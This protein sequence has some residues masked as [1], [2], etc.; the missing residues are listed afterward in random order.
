MCAPKAVISGRRVGWFGK[1]TA[2]GPKA[3]LFFHVGYQ[4]R[5]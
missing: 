4:P 5:T 3:L 2:L 1:R